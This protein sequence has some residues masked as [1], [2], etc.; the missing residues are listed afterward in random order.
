FRR[1]LFRSELDQVAGGKLQARC[2]AMPEI[3]K[4]SKGESKPDPHRAPAQ[5]L[6]KLDGMRPTV[7]DTQVQDQHDNH[8]QVEQHPKENQWRPQARRAC[9]MSTSNRRLSE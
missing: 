3:N 4:D 5:R 7:E 6:A 1:V 9:R 8:E 2:P